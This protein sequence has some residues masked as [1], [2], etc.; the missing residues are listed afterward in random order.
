MMIQI[1]NGGAGGYQHH[2]P[3]EKLLNFENV[4]ESP[5]SHRKKN[6]QMSFNVEIVSPKFLDH[7]NEKIEHNE[8]Y[9]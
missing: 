4:M 2:S 8:L 5:D 3:K 9:I 1:T 6:R 7:Y